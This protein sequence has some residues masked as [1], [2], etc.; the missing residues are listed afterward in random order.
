MS[1]AAGKRRIDR[2]L[3]VDFLEGIAELPLAEVRVLREEAEQEETD[4]SYIRRLVQARLD[5][6]GAELTRRAS[7]DA[8]SG[9]LLADLPRILA[10]SPRGTPRGLGRH[11]GSEP[12]RADE[13]RRYVEALVAD[14][15]LSDVSA[16]TDDELR[17]V[18][19]RLEEA[20][21][22]L[23]AKRKQVQQVHDACSAEVTRRYR[24]GE[25]DVADLLAG[26]PAI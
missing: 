2:V 26:P 18:Q 4:L 10:D 5:I 23:S 21:A 12:S 13:H 25:A 8:S 3:S 19:Q 7:G 15:D 17:R 14:V 24:D 16:R 9:S 1:D 6:I 22:E 11:Q 20:E